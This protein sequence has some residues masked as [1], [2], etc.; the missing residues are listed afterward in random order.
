MATVSPMRVAL[1]FDTESTASSASSAPI[2][3]N[4][5]CTFADPAGP[6]LRASPQPAA[7]AISFKASSG[8]LASTVTFFPEMWAGQSPA[9]SG[10]FGSG[11]PRV[12]RS[13][14]GNEVVTGLLLGDLAG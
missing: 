7:A 6:V 5:N 10:V 12:R 3:L 4:E 8:V 11:A 9:R 2:F 1:R 14:R 13:N